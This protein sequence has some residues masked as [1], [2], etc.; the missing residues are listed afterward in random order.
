[1]FGETTYPKPV[2]DV[3]RGHQGL[4]THI[5]STGGT[6]MVY[7]PGYAPEPVVESPGYLA[8]GYRSWRGR[9]IPS[10]TTPA[11]LMDPSIPVAAAEA[12]PADTSSSSIMDTISAMPTWQLIAIAAGA[13]FLFFKKGR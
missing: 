12:Q 6:D 4:P 10:A 8:P 11:P 2:W 9:R 13:Y 3:R 1:M 7:A 5:M